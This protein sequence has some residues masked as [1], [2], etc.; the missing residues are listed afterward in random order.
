MKDFKEM[1]E[2]MSST[3][4]GV[5][6]LTSIG[7][8]IHIVNLDM[9]GIEKSLSTWKGVFITSNE[10]GHPEGDHNVDLES[11]T[12]ISIYDTKFL[13]NNL[14]VTTR[15]SFITNERGCLTEDEESITYRTSIV[16][17]DSIIGL[18]ISPNPLPRNRILP[19]IES[20]LPSSP[21]L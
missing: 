4:V 15:E 11:F 7:E 13:K 9:F 10:K 17:Y 21:R 18:H 19:T 12:S 6:Q 1:V 5:L 8:P 14:V 20:E 2:L 3:D 16:D